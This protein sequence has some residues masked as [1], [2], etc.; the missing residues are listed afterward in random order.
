MTAG[1]VGR[2]LRAAAG[3]ALLLTVLD[4]YA[5]APL[6]W[7]PSG[8][9]VVLGLLLAYVAVHVAVVR[10][11]PRLN[12]WLGA[13]LAV[14][15]LLAVY[16][17]GGPAG[18]VGVVTFLGISLLL[19]AWRADAGCEVMA[20]PGAVFGR[21]THLMCLLFSPVDWIERRMRQPS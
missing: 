9:V 5:D 12:R 21:T 6:R 14:A 8:G 2:A 18:R 17:V 13:G 10:F 19:A 11:V 3:A 15:P 20:I 16:A 1:A 4:V 7:L